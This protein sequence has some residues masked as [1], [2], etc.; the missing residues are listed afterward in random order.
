VIWPR[1]FATPGNPLF[2]RKTMVRNSNT[3]IKQRMAKLDD[4][5][6]RCTV[7]PCT[8]P[9]MV[10]AKVG[11]AAGLCKYHT[12][13]RSRHGS[14]WCTSLSAKGLRPYTVEATRWIKDNRADSLVAYPLI[15]L[16]GLLD[17]A[18][19]V[20]PP[21]GLKLRSAAQK[22]RV[23]LARLRVAGIS[24]E[25]ILAVYIAV[26][27]LLTDDAY[28][29]RNDERYRLTQIAKPLMRLA[30]GFHVRGAYPDAGGAS[31]VSFVEHSYPRSSGL[32]CEF[33]RNPATDSELKP[34]GVPI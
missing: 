2:A 16:R 11:L 8:R 15:G 19:A 7:F 28:A 17:G 34:A 9:S 29:P 27:V 23:A 20:V 5:A 10:A 30:S 22:A 4:P 14:A 25:R 21:L 13:Y 1:R 24:P 3:A 6:G 32:A 26:S 18:G 31:V 12:Q 33:R